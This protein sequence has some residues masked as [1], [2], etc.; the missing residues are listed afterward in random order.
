MKRMQ[1]QNIVVHSEREIVGIRAAAAAT[2]HV[3]DQLADL[4]KPGL[5]TLEVDQLAGKLIAETGGTS[6][7]Y[8]YRGFPGQICI[9]L[10]DEVVH[11]IGSA[12]RIIQFGDLVSIDVGVQL[13]DF[14]GDTAVTISTNPNADVQINALL[15]AT[16]ESLAAGISAAQ[17]GN[18][19]NHIGR[20]VE[21]VV[22]RSGFNVVR[23]FVGHGCGCSLHE[24]PEVPNFAQAHKGPKLRAGM[25]LAIEPMV[26]TGTGNVTVDDDGWTVRT[27]DAGLSAHFEHMI[28]I[29]EKE[30]EILTWQKTI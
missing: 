24:P 4:I 29:T 25:V 17:G 23:D 15:R 7:F 1:R 30:P 9:S 28:L 20:A 27:A 5:T 10:N 6:A 11:G 18:Y 21:N 26:N 22:R 13:N 16:Q 2:A 14:I 19:V 8:Q 12:G 3:R